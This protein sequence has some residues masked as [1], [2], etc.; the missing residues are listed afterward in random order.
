MTIDTLTLFHK[1][2]QAGFDRVQAETIIECVTESQ[3]EL[4]T[5]AILPEELGRE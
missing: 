1:L 5:S 4:V 3:K 2:E